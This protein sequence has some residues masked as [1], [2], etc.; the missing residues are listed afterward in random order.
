MQNTELDKLLATL[1]AEIEP[2]E[3]LWPQLAKNLTAR[4]KQRFSPWLS[5]GLAAAIALL[6]VIWWQPFS[7]TPTAATLA[8]L[9]QQYQQQLSLQLASIEQIDPAYGDWQWQLALWQQ[10]ITQVRQALGFYP[11]DA[12]LQQQLL[13]L[14]QQQ[15]DY[16]S[17]LAVVS[18]AYY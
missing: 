15:L 17:T 3:D 11:D 7:N 8:Q 18:P 13:S 16:V 9:E 10:A 2:P 14:Y 4:P 12:N 6:L 5:G 1:P